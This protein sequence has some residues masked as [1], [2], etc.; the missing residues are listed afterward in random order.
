[1]VTVTG[2]DHNAATGVVGAERRTGNR[3]MQVVDVDGKKVRTFRTGHGRNLVYLHSGFGEGG[4]L[5]L[6]HAL[7]AKGFAVTAPLLPGF[8]GSDPANE[9]HRIEDVVF[10]L[11]RLFVALGVERPVLMG[12]SLGGWLAAELAIWFPEKVAGLVLVD[13]FGLR[14]EGHPIFEVFGSPPREVSRRAFPKGGDVVPFVRGVL[15]E[16]D[17]PDALRLHFFSALEATARI[18]WNPYLHDPKLLGRLGFVEAP[19]LV[20][21]GADDGI[22][23][24]EHGRVFS[25]SISGARLEV[26]EGCGHL[27]A[28]EAP[29]LLAEKVSLLMGE[30]TR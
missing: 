11:R 22:V 30:S 29:E 7:A 20:V 10:F 16:P 17:A 21:W 5:E 1:M 27:P 2:G 14:V 8:G 19:T 6:F 13:A 28:L 9:W 23:P 25:E 4:P 12:S 24:V 18:G 15:E 26:V 3:A